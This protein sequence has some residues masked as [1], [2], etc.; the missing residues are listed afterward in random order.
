MKSIICKLFIKPDRAD[1]FITVS[2]Y[3]SENSLREPGCS[4]FDL[5]RIIDDPATFFLYEVYDDLAAFEFHKTTAHYA[6]WRDTVADLQAKPRESLK[7]DILSDA[8]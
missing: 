5:V 1:E 2:K 3:N 8:K 6:K 4:R 7:G